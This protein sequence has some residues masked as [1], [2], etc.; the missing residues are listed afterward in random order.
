MPAYRSAPQIGAVLAQIPP[1]VHRI[2]V[3]DDASPDDLA[4]AVNAPADPRVVILRHPVNRG[5]GAATLTGS[6]SRDRLG[7]TWW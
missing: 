2:V 4:R 6:A 3:V 7:P 1:L 5:V